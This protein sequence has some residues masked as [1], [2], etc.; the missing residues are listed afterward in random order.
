M[1][2]ILDLGR[3]LTSFECKKLE[4]NA[5]IVVY[6]D[7]HDTNIAYNQNYAANDNSIFGLTIDLKDEESI[8]FN[9]KF[10]EL[11]LFAKTLNNH[12]EIIK[13]TYSEQIKHQRKLGGDI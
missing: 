5:K 4:G 13:E 2:T 11:E 12:L 7:M 10:E 9:L 6:S 1:E 3:I 8:M